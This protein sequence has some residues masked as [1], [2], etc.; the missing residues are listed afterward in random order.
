MTLALIE[1][2]DR[3]VESAEDQAARIGRLIL[4]CLVKDWRSKFLLINSL[5]NLEITL[6]ITRKGH[7]V[8]QSIMMSFYFGVRKQRYPITSH[9][10]KN[11]NGVFF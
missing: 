11:S 1:I 10:T 8:L 3:A 9:H 4:D 2:N 7:F 6:E 5:N